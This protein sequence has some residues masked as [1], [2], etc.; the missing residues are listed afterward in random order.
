MPITCAI[1]KWQKTN[2]DLPNRIIIY[3]DGV[4]DGQL[5][6]LFD[7]E[8]PQ[9]LSLF[10]E[11]PATYN[12]KV[13]VVVVR[14]RCTTRFFTQSQRG[15]QNP[16][17][18]TI[19]DSEVTRPEWYDF[20]LISQNARQGSVNPTHYNVLYDTNCLRPDH[21]QRLT[22]KLCHLYYNWP[23]IG[24]LAEIIQQQSQARY[25]CYSDLCW[26]MVTCALILRSKN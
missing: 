7:Y 6:M 11:P 18:G 4:G 12:P 8:I 19:I 3:R 10:K 17:L 25:L 14:K 13:T 16:P 2:N 23:Y 20:F 9:L 15:F 21:L 26:W 1:E 24:D 5:Q 22:Y